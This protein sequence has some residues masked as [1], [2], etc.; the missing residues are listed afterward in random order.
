MKGHR[1]RVATKGTQD[2]R[3]FLKETFVLFVPFVAKNKCRI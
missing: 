3:D 2:G 1:R